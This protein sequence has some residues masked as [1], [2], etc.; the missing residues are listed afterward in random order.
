MSRLLTIILIL[1]CCQPALGQLTAR[2]TAD[3]TGGCGP[4]VVHFADQSSGVTAAAGYQWDLGNGNTAVVADPVATYTQPGVYAVTLTVNNGAQSSTYSQ[5]ITVYAAP[6]AAFTVSAT[7]VCA[8]APIQFM[9]TSTAGS[10]A[11]ASYLWDFGD[12]ATLSGAVPSIGHSY[13][14]AG[15]EG[16]SLTVTDV[17]GCTST[18]V[19]PALL[20][21][22]PAMNVGFT[23]SNRFLCN[24]GD[25]EQFTNS[26]T[27]PG[28]LSYSWSFGDGGTSTQ[29]S[30]SYSYPAQGTYTVML[31][32]ASSLGC[33]VSDT[34]TNVVNV[35]NFQAGFTLPPNVCVGATTIFGDQSTPTP[36]HQQW[37]VDGSIA[38]RP[39]YP[40]MSFA[41]PAAGTHTVTEVDY[42]GACQRSV[43]HTVNVNALPAIPAF[44]AVV[45]NSCGAPVTVKFLD[46]TPGAVNWSWAFNYNYYTG[47]QVTVSGGPANSFQ[48]N[49]NQT[50]WVQL[51]V[52]NAAGC[53][54]QVIQ[55]VTIAAPVV[56]IIE[57]DNQPEGSCGTPLTKSFACPQ[58][59]NL[60]SW[61]WNFGDGATSTSATPTHTFNTP[62]SFNTTLTWTDKNGCTGTTSGIP[63]IISTP[64]TPSFF[65]NDTVVCAGQTVF[66]A[67]PAQINAAFVSWSFGDGQGGYIYSGG[68]EEHSY[69][70]P[71]V[72][73]VSLTLTNDAGCNY[74][75]TKTSYIRV[76]PT[77]VIGFS[78]SNTCTG[79]R[80]N[81]TFHV[82]VSGADSLY[83]QFGDGTTLRT[84]STVTQLVHHYAYDG[85]WAASVLATNGTCPVSAGL[86][87]I[88]QP[89][90]AS[91]T[92]TAT[93]SPG[94]VDVCPNTS[95]AAIIHAPT[96]NSQNDYYPMQQVLFQ[97]GDSSFYPSFNYQSNGETYADIYSYTLN[98]GF[99]PG[100]N[101]LRVIAQDELGCADTSNW[102][103]LVVGGAKAGFEI[104][105][106]D[107]CYQQPVVLKD[108]SKSAA[109]DPIVSW[110]WSFGDGASSAQS[111]TVSHVY[112]NPGNYDVQLTVNDEL[113]CAT[114][115]QAFA[116]PVSVNGPQAAFNIPAGTVLP[117]GTM[118]QFNNISNTYGTTNVTWLWNF[119]DG[120]TSAAYYPTHGYPKPG[121]YLVTLTATDAVSGCTSVATVTL[122]IKVFNTVFGSASSYVTTGSC[123][124]LL[125]RFTSYANYYTS[126]TWD[127]GDGDS[128]SNVLYPSHVYAK[129]GKYYVML[130]VVGVNGETVKTV[131]SVV[132]LAPVAA[133]E[134]AV[135]AICAGQT[136]TLRSKGDVGVSA[137][138][139]DFGDGTVG[140][141]VDSTATHVYPTPGNYTA[142]L[143]V[144]D[145]LGCSAVASSSDVIN[146]HAPPVVGVTPPQ[147]V[148]CLGKGTSI[149]AIG[150]GTYSWSPAAGLSDAGIAA[151]VASPV[152]NTVYTVTVTDDI[153]CT[154]SDSIVVSVVRPDTVS[155]S[156]DSVALCPG[157]TVTLQ[158][159][160]ASNYRWIGAVDGLSATDIAAPVVSP[161]ASMVYEVAGSDRYGCF[162]DTVPVIVNLLIAP[163]VNAGPD[164]QVLAETPV[165]IAAVGSADVVRWQWMPPTDLSC[166][167]CAQPV[168]VP[169]QDERYVVTVA[170]GDGCE[171]S[172]TVAVKLICDEARVRIPDAFTPNGDG[173]NDRFT[174]I[175]AIS[176]VNH[177]V[178]FDRW[179][180]KVFEAD[181]FYPAAQ[182]S[183]WD[184][185]MGGKPAPAGVYAYFV[186]MQ[187]PAG[188]V[189]VRKGTVVLVR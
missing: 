10:G 16:V 174:V 87:V 59:A 109:G 78:Y 71:G 96:R 143:V 187:C 90:P 107:Q 85:G 115:T 28:T 80:G 5:T 178:I 51:T 48:Y 168:C 58:I 22:L 101:R 121:N 184:G 68:T 84:D 145:S 108:T 67:A 65:T 189:F 99:Q 114:T 105:S 157:K 91:F 162:T 53:S 39:I 185:T 26:S 60:S 61:T 176:I 181:H 147:A 17:Y 165:T 89:T 50:Y 117:Q 54:A 25:P 15:V 138:N 57:T 110:V 146:V 127:F 166:A 92:L 66:F 45:Q 72:Y 64:L 98:G 83:W 131:D 140:T 150:G 173:H 120:T 44:D 38:A 46:H 32:A 151:P 177:L 34:Q 77:P 42:F 130:T 119:G 55:P 24:A 43:S 136:D 144:A 70:Q 21:V 23:E 74:T 116:Q 30:P 1:C 97:Y 40:P 125:V 37:L 33:V 124:P 179:G 35:A 18:Q 122:T 47:N 104:V 155:V 137:Y 4:L 163:A 152:V 49:S 132:V 27:G 118:V 69:S 159:S 128:V 129:P 76:L 106:D 123:P 52:T 11:I 133:L 161:V 82:Q 86:D 156:P 102:I 29:T 79:D 149:T 103:N 148:V 14:A 73:T 93:G 63:T 62:G 41:F 180:A 31:T 126:I 95:L 139:W 3:K 134:A 186:E 112:A 9:S 158:A 20:T 154:N 6:T 167:D 111:G 100:E 19:Q 172:D 164:L 94:N 160:G 75:L 12:G 81:V 88:V 56:N 175:G 169:R 142:K 153:G 36:T 170:A 188:A 2:F 7:K 135:P 182:G 13:S 183:G 8:P 171:A 141:G 113:G